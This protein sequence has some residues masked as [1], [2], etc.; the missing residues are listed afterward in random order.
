MDVHDEWKKKKERELEVDWGLHGFGTEQILAG[1]SPFLYLW[2][3]T[4]SGGEVG[5]G[6]GFLQDPNTLVPCLEAPQ[7]G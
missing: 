7:G 1:L 3:L 6:V 2:V 4:G 5:G